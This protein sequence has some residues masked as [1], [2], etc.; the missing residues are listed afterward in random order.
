MDVV[1][2]QPKVGLL[3]KVKNLPAIPLSLITVATNL[4]EDYKVK[5]VDQRTDPTWRA[6]LKFYIG[7]YKPLAVGTTAMLGP[8]IA[9]ALEALAIVKSTNPN[10]PTIW[11]GPQGGIMP[12]ITINHP[13]IDYVIQGDGEQ[14]LKLLVDQLSVQGSTFA[15]DDIPGLF[16]KDQ[17]RYTPWELIDINKEPD[18][19]WHLVGIKKY[20]P[21]R[22]GKPTGD[23]ETSRGCVFGCKFCYN[24]Y[25]HKRKWR[26]LSPIIAKERI[27]KLNKLYEMESFWFIDDEFFVDL[28][29]A[30]EII[31]FMLSHKFTWSVQGT[32]VANVLRMNDDFLSL[33][34][35]SGCRQLNIGVESGAP[36]ILRLIGKKVNPEDVIHINLLLK[37]H[38]IIPSYYFV[39]GFPTETLEDIKH[40]VNLIT[41]LLKDN[42]QA[43][44]MNIGCFTPYPSS[45]IM[46]LC[47][48]LGYKQPE[49]LKDYINYGVETINTPWVLDSPPLY[50][51]IKSINFLNYFLDNKINDLEIPGYM[52]IPAKL[53]TPLARWRFNNKNF[54]IPIDI[55]IGTYLRS[56]I[57]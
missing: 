40:T 29:R 28:D 55:N 48:T 19:P 14:S 45:E 12:Q 9:H 56:K 51:I 18:P 17:K 20:L 16:Y 54:S 38:N 41:I 32:T 37:H 26:A 57:S 5:I 22:F 39:V 53:Y 13:L 11:G 1:L 23:F 52:R 34:Y 8:Q 46:K 7:K 2:V 4:V 30:Y 27:L 21:T 33:L 47:E 44:I 36:R 49:K 50:K 43:K 35:K 15:L 3:D 25:L 42:P 31:E 24:P 10:I 6:T